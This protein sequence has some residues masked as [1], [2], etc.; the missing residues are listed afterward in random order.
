LPLISHP[1]QIL[2][3]RSQLKGLRNMEYF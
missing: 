3:S 2:R 1:H